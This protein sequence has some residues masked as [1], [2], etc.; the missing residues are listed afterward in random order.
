LRF[1]TVTGD[2]GQ[3][4]TDGFGSVHSLWTKPALAQLVKPALHPKPISGPL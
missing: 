4:A 2:E 3:T 1:G